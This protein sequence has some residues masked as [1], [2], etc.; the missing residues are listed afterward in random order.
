MTI[1]IDGRSIVF[2]GRPTLLEVA[3][4]GGID[5]PSLCDHHDLAP[6]GA[7]RIC[8]VEVKGRKGYLPA[9]S[10]VAEDGLEV[11]TATP[12]IKVLRRQI[13]ELILAEHPNA[14]LIC[15]EKKSCDE[16][17]STIRKTD[18]VT[19]CVLCPANGRCELQRV[20]EAVGVERVHF[21]SARREGEVRRDD[22]FI[23]RDNSLCILCGRCVRVCHE[24]R[25]ASV[26]TFVSRGS[27][28]VIGTA[29][30]RRLLDSACRFCGACVDVC[31]TGSLAE[32]AVRYERPAE[33]ERRALC[34]L[35]GQGC[36]LRVGLR[37]GRV[38][39]AVPDPGGPANRGQACVKGRFLVRSAVDHPL[40]LRRPLVRRDGRL[41]E[42]SWDEAL[43]IA[44]GRLSATGAG[45]AAVVLSAQSSCEDLFV[46]HRFAAEILKSPVVAGTWAGSAAAEL[47]NLG[48]AAG[49]KTPLGFRFS[50]I[51]RAEAVVVIGED[52][53]VIQ[54]ILGVEVNR[55]AR[56][57]AALLSVGP[58]GFRHAREASIK[59][60]VPS[61]RETDFLSALA[62]MILKVR[63]QSPV[64]S[65]GA[66]K[67]KAGLKAFDLAGT[68]SALKMSE[69]KLAGIARV[70]EMRRPALFF[71]GPAFLASAG[72]AGGLAALWNLAVLVEGRIIPLDAEANLRGGLE[73]AGA[74]P[75]KALSGEELA[76][77]VARRE[78]KALYIAGPLPKLEPGAA[79]FVIV[80]GSYDG[81][82]AAVADVI[83]PETTS[84]EADGIFVNV[85]GRVQRSGEAVEPRGEAR[86]GWIIL[87]E[88]AA[89]LGYSG[90]AYTSAEDI[91][92]DIARAIPAFGNLGPVPP[93]QEGL[94][95]AEEAAGR[96]AFIAGDSLP[97]RAA[98][99]RPATPRDPDDYKGLHLARENKSLKLVRGR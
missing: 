86:P 35:C 65:T 98:G 76:A 13:L 14:C 60:E 61:G 29:M 49:A 17:K 38:L 99:L 32:R 46:M 8:L 26:L 82:N 1:I 96:A 22:P 10:T 23:D 57:G 68:L 39:G 67:F 81:G 42:A 44:A 51:C 90:F 75:T 18:E 73:I 41:E 15:D 62:A 7:C 69:D 9:C 27:K 4:A 56:N 85:E 20:I 94:F 93:P 79:E 77:A 33:T 50:D 78:V 28:T 92:K 72:P 43:T 63:G 87:G 31:P 71:F 48:R 37:E 95:L 47:R 21:P 74:F 64:K 52:L 53:P 80:Q 58:E 34:P 97:E 84:F 45:E 5:I 91:R 2:E 11:R 89:R 40:R 30:D 70:L 12:E 3:R 19:G 54:P 88:L 16:Y 36:E 25:G 6:F 24:V 59:V 55:A 83:F 66:A